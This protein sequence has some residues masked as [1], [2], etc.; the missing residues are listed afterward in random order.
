MDMGVPP[1]ILA[2]SLLL[3]IAQ[4]LVRLVCEH[5]AEPYAL[6]EEEIEMLGV[7][8]AQLASATP[9]IGHGCKVCMGI[10]YRG[11]V[12]VFET[13][14]A[15]REVKE[16]IR[17]QAG[18]EALLAAARA[19]GTRTIFESGVEKVLRGETTPAELK[20]VLQIET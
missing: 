17:R 16:L 5:C 4:R 18:P 11:R 6:S 19:A 8:A 3:V 15:T 10:G 14:Q 13:V 12:A 7:D 1:Y 9:R 2:S 20:R